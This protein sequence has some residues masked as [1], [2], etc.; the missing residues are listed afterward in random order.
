[1]DW[2]EYRKDVLRTAAPADEAESLI[3]AAL[4]LTGESGEFSE[5]IK[6]YAFH[7]HQLDTDNAKEELGDVFYYWTLAADKLG[8]TFEEILAAN[9]EKRAARYPNGFTHQDSLRRADV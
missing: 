2:N 3:I 4:G 1:M 6:K 8:L 7:G 5:L 9:V